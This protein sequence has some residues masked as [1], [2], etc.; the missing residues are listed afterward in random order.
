MCRRYQRQGEFT[1]KMSLLLV[2]WTTLGLQPAFAQSDMVRRCNLATASADDVTRPHD[3]PGV[4]FDQINPAVAVP[5]CEA[6]VSANPGVARLQFELGRALEAAKRLGE[7]RAAYERAAAKDFALAEANLAT[8]YRLGEGVPKDYVKSMA[9]YRKAADQGLASAQVNVGHLY[10]EGDG[11]AKNYAEAMKWYRRAADQGDQDGQA[12]LG[13]MYFNGRGVQKDPSQAFDWFRKA[14]EQGNVDSQSM[15]GWMYWEG[16]GVPKDNAQAASWFRKAADQGDADAQ[17]ALG[18]MYVDGEG[19]P[20]DNGKAEFWYRKAAAQGNTVAQS[21][22]KGLANL[23]Q[24]NQETAAQETRQ[25]ALLAKRKEVGDL[26]CNADGVVWGYVE[27]VYKDKIQIRYQH[28]FFVS[29]PYDELFWKNY[30]E[31]IVCSDK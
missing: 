28:T 22:L 25:A 1:V 9:W 15:L 17:T 21:K 13:E 27:R 3:I 14:A 29:H 11:V 12:K 8:L 10:Y 2:F 24:V 6:A 26:V 5:A 31:V 18:A 23:A 30:N 4:A 7:A 16:I 19:V 20:K